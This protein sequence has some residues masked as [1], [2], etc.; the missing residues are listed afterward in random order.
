MEPKLGYSYFS[1]INNVGN[2]KQKV[3]QFIELTAD[4]GSDSRFEM[5]AIFS[6][7]DL[8]LAEMYLMRFCDKLFEGEQN[9]HF[10]ALVFDISDFFMEFLLILFDGL[11]NSI[12]NLTI[13]MDRVAGIIFELGS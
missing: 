8:F 4:E 12:F 13:E 9:L 6:Y 10:I 3:Y 2:L 1:L 7:A 11:I 5:S